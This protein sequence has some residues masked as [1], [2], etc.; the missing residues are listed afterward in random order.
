MSVQTVLVILENIGQRVLFL[1]PVSFAGKRYS[2]SLKSMP[3]ATSVR[4]RVG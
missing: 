4:K 1:K 2:L 3:I